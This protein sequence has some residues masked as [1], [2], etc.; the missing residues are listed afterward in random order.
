MVAN[1]TVNP[2]RAIVDSIKKPVGKKLIPLSLG[3]P[4]HFGNLNPPAMLTDTVAESAKSLKHNGYAHSAGTLD[5]REAVAKAFSARV[6]SSPVTAGDVV[7]ANGAS[8][9]LDLAI[10]VLCNPGDSLLV[11][12]PGFSLYETLAKSKGVNVQHYNLDPARGWD[13][14]LDHLEAQITNRTR[15][16]LVNNPS[17]PCGSVYT[18][19]HLKAILAI[20]ER[21]RIPI[22]TDEIYGDLVWDGAEYFPIA[23]LTDTVPVLTVSGLAKL[24]LVPGWR[25]GWVI[26]NDKGGVFEKVRTGLFKMSQLILGATRIV[27]P[28]IVR[29]L[30]PSTDEDKAAMAEF[31]KSTREKLEVNAHVCVEKLSGIAGL[32]VVVPRGAMYVMV[33][34]DTERLGDISDDMDFCQKLL[35]EEAVFVLPGQCFGMKNFFRIVFCAPPDVLGEACDKI[36]AFCG[37]RAEA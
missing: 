23:G 19:D 10:G 5:A 16:I 29:C 13:V 34:V 1:N 37:R 15:A 6:P 18:K 36:S 11:P 9:A 27:Q 14:D 8:G 32:R 24:F 3:D 35:D 22:I 28:A 17:N 26:V 7:I 12:C 21:H 30:T 4:T 20:A 2:I 33:G 25:V 31:H